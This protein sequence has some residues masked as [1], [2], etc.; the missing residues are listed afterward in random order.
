MK[1]TLIILTTVVLSA[2]LAAPASAADTGWHL[3]IFA[4]G[5]DPDLDETVPA[6]NPEEVRVTAESDLGYGLSLEYQFSSHW[7][8]E[9]GF[10]KGSP[11]VEIRGEIPD[12]GE[13]SLSDT[14]P[15]TALTLD[16]DLHLIPNSPAFDVFLGVGI[17]RMSYRD[18]F[19]EFEDANESFGVQVNNDTTWSVKA[20]L[21]IALGGS[22]W[23]ATAGLRYTDSNLVVS[24]TEDAPSETET[25]DFGLI[26]FTVG[27]GYR[28]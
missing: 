10:M 27:I 22:S 15:T 19:Y 2:T 25:F 26:N 24:N 16:V 4:A 17:V 18:L 6:E 3:R 1:Q 23:S 5:F 20:G 28:F 14:M 11:A 21:D 7:G 12:Y 13:F 9:A 8:L